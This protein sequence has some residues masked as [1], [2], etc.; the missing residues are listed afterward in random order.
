MRMPVFLGQSIVGP[1]PVFS[2]SLCCCMRFSGHDRARYSLF[3]I[4]WTWQP[5]SVSLGL[6]P[7]MSR[8]NNAPAMLLYLRLDG[9]SSISNAIVYQLRTFRC[10]MAATYLFPRSAT[11][12]FVS[13]RAFRHS[14][15]IRNFKVPPPEYALERAQV[16]RR[17]R[18]PTRREY[19][20]GGGALLRYIRR[21]I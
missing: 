10:P 9:P 19:E 2:W 12:F 3:Q 20:N 16:I 5:F 14:R 13:T 8:V 18:L 17:I 15:D 4:T 21:P 6:P 11:V 7:F 1:L